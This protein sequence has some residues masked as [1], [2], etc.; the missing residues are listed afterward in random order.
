MQVAPNIVLDFGDL[1]LLNVCEFNSVAT[2]VMYLVAIDHIRIRGGNVQIYSAVQGHEKVCVPWSTWYYQRWQVR[3]PQPTV[4]IEQIY[5]DEVGPGVRNKEVLSRGVDR[6]KVWQRLMQFS[7]WMYC[8]LGQ[9]ISLRLNQ[10]QGSRV[11]HGHIVSCHSRANAVQN[12]TVKYQL[13]NP[14]VS[15][16][17]RRRVNA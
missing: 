17:E 1:A 14:M 11:C 9:V 8:L 3:K 6:G 5:P 2:R 16:T 10:L 4:L 12:K 13:K 7:H 15:I